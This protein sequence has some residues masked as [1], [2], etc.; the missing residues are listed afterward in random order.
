MQPVPWVWRSRSG[1]RQDLG[2]PLPS[3]RTSMLSGPPRW[4]PL[5]RTA[6]GPQRTQ[7]RRR[8]DHARLVAGPARCRADAGLGQVR[9]DQRG[10]RQEALAERA[11]RFLRAAG[12]RRSWR[13]SP[14]RARCYRARCRC[15]ASAT[16][17]ITSG[18]ESMPI[19]TAAISMSSNTASSWA[20][21]NSGGTSW[22]ARHRARVLRGQR[23]DHRAAV[24]AERREGLE[25]G[26]DAGAAA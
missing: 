10:Q 15:N 6:R 1:A 7:R 21:T 8:G 22:I 14:G 24:G 16:A 19:L 11:D 25:V 20:V 23:G 17:T 26:L 9:G 2:S 18:R 13:P 3:S 4:P 5:T 12:D